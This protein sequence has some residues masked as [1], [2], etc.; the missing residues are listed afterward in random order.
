MYLSTIACL[1]GDFT[2]AERE[3]RAA[4]DAVATVP[5]LYASVLA[6]LARALLAQ[7]TGRAKEA[8]EAARGAM[9][10]IESLGGIEDYEALARL[11]YAE[12]LDAVGEPDRARAAL[13]A[14]RARLLDRAAR[15]SDPQLRTSFLTQVPDN[16]RTLQLA[17]TWELP[18]EL[19]E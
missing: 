8:L 16:A 5:P 17:R 15:I 18:L 7:G 10:V 14:A 19:H 12:A 13:E 6:T 3:A 4:A 11:V 1:G 2:E 9:D